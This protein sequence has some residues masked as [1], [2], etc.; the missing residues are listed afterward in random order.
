M[1]GAALAK[2]GAVFDTNMLSGVWPLLHFCLI[3]R[4]LTMH[5]CGRPAECCGNV[6]PLFYGFA[7]MDR[8]I[9]NLRYVLTAGFRSVQTVMSNT[10]KASK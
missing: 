1:H 2:C 7:E 9:K 8:C 3:F 4:C 6:R 10:P 5:F